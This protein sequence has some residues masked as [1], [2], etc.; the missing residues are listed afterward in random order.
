[1]AMEV[2]HKLNITD[3]SRFDIKECLNIKGFNWQKMKC[4]VEEYMT[5]QARANR[6]PWWGYFRCKYYDEK[7]DSMLML[8]IY[9]S[10]KLSIMQHW[11]LAGVCLAET[12]TQ[13]LEDS[14]FI[15]S[16]L[17]VK[18][19]DIP[20]SEDW[21]I[22]E[23]VTRVLEE[24]TKT[25]LIK[26]LQEVTNEFE[27]KRDKEIAEEMAFLQSY[28]YDFTGRRSYKKIKRNRKIYR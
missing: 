25:K 21:V 18:V 6:I 2:I 26:V 5:H 1:M 3:E 28:Y 4:E 19:Q 8:F 13:E 10:N 14:G 22:R 24:T 12:W 17:K 11:D 15:R 23:R 16:W 7:S 27:C 20:E 9:K